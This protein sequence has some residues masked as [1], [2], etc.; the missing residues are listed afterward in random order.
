MGTASIKLE[1]V[2]AKRLVQTSSA[3]KGEQ[4]V[5]H[6]WLLAGYHTCNDWTLGLTYGFHVIICVGF[7]F[8]HPL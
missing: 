4:K 2:R 7:T 5:S 8:S 3:L 6:M 1:E